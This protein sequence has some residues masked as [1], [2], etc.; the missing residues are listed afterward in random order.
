VSD[1]GR[2]VA[3]LAFVAVYAALNYGARFSGEGPDRSVLY[4][5]SA[6]VFGLLQLG[7][8]LGLMLLITLNRPKREYF[9]LRRPVSWPRAVS[10]G[11]LV[12]IGVF[13]VG[14]ILEPFLHP[15]HEQGIVPEKWQPEHAA[16][17]AFN[18]VVVAL[19]APV[20]EELT[21]RGLGYRLLQRFGQVAAILLV[22][23]LFG[24]AHGLV[25]ALPIL[26]AF[27]AGLAYLRARTRSVYPG[28]LVHAGFN[29]LVLVRAVAI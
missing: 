9:A 25:E 2:L 26:A 17:F 11:V 22:G 29:S 8:I 7:I 4:T 24:L 10:L 14:G 21:F 13:V 28:M 18:F 23:L 6:A 16:A 1:R 15:G 27:G 3:W 12:L 19:L 5:Y 20:V